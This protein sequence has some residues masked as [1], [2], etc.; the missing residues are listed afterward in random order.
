M[1]EGWIRRNGIAR[2]DKATLTEYWMRHDDV[3]TLVS[4][5]NDPV[6]LTEPFMRTWNWTLDAGVHITP[7][8]CVPKVETDRPQGYVA[9]W[10][11]GQ[12][13]FLNELPAKT[14]LPAAIFRGGREQ[15]YPEYQDSLATSPAA[16][17]PAPAAAQP[18]LAHASQR[19][20][21][22]PA[23]S[24]DPAEAEL[25]VVRVRDN[26]FMLVGPASNTTVEFGDDGVMV[27][28]TQSAAIAPK[29]LAAIKKL[30]D[31]PIRY[32]V[33]TDVLA[34]NTGGN[35]IINKAGKF[36]GWR[37]ETKAADILAHENVLQ[38]MSGTLGNAPAI[39]AAAWPQDTYYKASMDLHF[40]GEAIQL[41]H[42]P[43][44]HTDGDSI[45]FFRGSD[46]I[47][48]GDLF[49]P[50]AYPHIDAALGGSFQGLIDALNRLIDMAIP[51]FNEEGGTMIIPG[52][53]RLTDE[54]ELVTYRDMLTIIR[55]RV[56]DM[57]ARGFTLK[58]VL[59]A[60]PSSDYDGMYGSD[61]STWTAAQFVESVYTDLK[62]HTAGH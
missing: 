53:G 45:V 10:L 29:I 20:P 31:Q 6:Y 41:I 5:V 61:K 59:D 2:S 1:K 9:H 17:A 44:A 58:Q 25:D 49:V 39:D 3:L 18:D 4:I 43:N 32:I 23:P 13:P 48:T 60:K 40:N 50:E 33:N 15:N 46:V 62:R 21:R 12:N 22:D 52:H 14:H 57:I 42:E 37:G 38:R 7:Y 16:S 34:A 35:I 47:C 8:T 36:I 55:D 56:Q 28:N 54:Y 30:T 24:A 19:K 27:V 11:P 51:D 26:I